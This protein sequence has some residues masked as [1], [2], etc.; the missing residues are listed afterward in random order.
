MLALAWRGILRD[1]DRSLLAVAS[2]AIAA[3]ILAGA[4]ALPDG[5][6]PSAQIGA[7]A[8]VG[9]D[10]LAMAQPLPG[11]AASGNW[12]WV[13]AQH[14]Y[15]TDL[16]L[17]F[18]G[19]LGSLE[20]AGA[21]SALTSQQLRRLAALPGVTAV[22]PD[23]AM[24]ALGPGGRQVVLRG[25]DSTL[26]ARLGVQ[27]LIQSGRPLA[28]GD[29]M[30][31]VVDAAAG[32]PPASLTLQVPTLRGSVWDYGSLRTLHLRVVGGYRA[33]ADQPAQVETAQGTEVVGPTG[34][35]STTAYWP[36]PDV[37]I[38]LSTW[39]A[40]WARA[41]HGAPFAPAQAGLI[42]ANTLRAATVAKAASAIVPAAIE[43]PDLVAVAGDSFVQLG[44]S[45]VVTSTRA[46]GVPLAL[47]GLVAALAIVAAAMVMAGT[48]LTLVAGRRH[49][50]G[51][52]KALGA[53]PATIA[54]MVAGEAGGLALLGGALGFAATRLV[55]TVILLAAHAPAGEIVLG[56]LREAGIVLGACLV[57]ALLCASLPAAEAAR[58]PTM[59]VLRE[60]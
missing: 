48:M 31:A 51:V 36:S 46:P 47:G 13:P 54:G 56:G 24:P 50:I 53:S 23:Y 39:L 59:A 8:I 32:P 11:P 19:T 45:P 5:F 60:S 28:A 29:G 12:A 37:W 17:F 41:T 58:L 22:Y 20:P 25:R 30:D 43:V 2:V 52:L 18:P 10:V 27:H 3:A 7:R 4:L 38:P 49:E 26:D 15:R 9:G 44:G 14:T 35:E 34:P 42:V 21:P 57:A 16:P 1:L 40:I 55:V 33:P 6:P